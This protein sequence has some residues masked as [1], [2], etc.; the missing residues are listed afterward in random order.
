MPF[1]LTPPDPKHIELVDKTAE[2]GS[3][4]DLNPGGGPAPG[5]IHG[6]WRKGNGG[7]AY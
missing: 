3:Q 1:A 6:T 2:K 5:Q 4:G 7:G